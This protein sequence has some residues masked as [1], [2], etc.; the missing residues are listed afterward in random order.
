ML[1]DIEMIECSLQGKNIVKEENIASYW[2]VPINEVKMNST[3]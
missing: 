3:F 1:I 2:S